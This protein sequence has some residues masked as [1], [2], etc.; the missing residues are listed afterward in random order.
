MLQQSICFPHPEPTSFDLLAVSHK[1][2]LAWIHAHPWPTGV[3]G[4]HSAGQT[5]TTLICF[6]ISY[7]LFLRQEI[8]GRS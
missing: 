6:A 4:P 8:R 1:A 5:T 2:S 3:S 7:V